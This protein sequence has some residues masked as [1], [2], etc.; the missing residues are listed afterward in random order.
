MT[1]ICR[2]QKK[3]VGAITISPQKIKGLSGDW[4]IILH[5]TIESTTITSA[6]G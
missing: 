1:T 3:K 2:K 4:W 5:Y 6:S